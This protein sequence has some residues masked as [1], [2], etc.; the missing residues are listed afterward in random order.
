MVSYLHRPVYRPT[1]GKLRD[2]LAQT[3]L[4]KACLAEYC[5]DLIGVFSKAVRSCAS[6]GSRMGGRIHAADLTKLR[7]T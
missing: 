1:A 4:Y 7:C 2:G 6:E 5:A 3:W